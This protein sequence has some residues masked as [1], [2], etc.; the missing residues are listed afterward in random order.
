ML[1]AE[2]RIE[3]A[4]VR[5]MNHPATMAY[6][7]LI[8]VGDTRVSDEVPTAYTNGRDKTYGRAFVNSLSDKELVGLILH[9]AGHIMYQHAYLWKHLWKKNSD[10]ANQAAD[11]VVNIELH[12]MSIA[13]P[14]LLALPA[15]GLLDNSYRGMNTQQVFDLLMQN[16]GNTGGGGFDSHD[17]ED[18]SADECEAL[19][20]EVESAIREGSYLSG[21]KGGNAP[22][23][24]AELT[25]PKVNWHEQLRAFAIDSAKGSDD[26]SWRKLNRRWLSAGVLVP[27]SES[28]SVPRI[29]IVFDVSGSIAG[30]SLVSAFM[31]E[32]VSICN[33]L[34]PNVVDM[35]CCDAAI[36][37]HDVYD[38]TSY[39][40]LEQLR[41]FKGGGGTDMRVALDYIE[42][43]GLNPAVVV[44]LTDGY[45][46][47]PTELS[48]P[49]LWAITSRNRA[50]PVGTTIHI[51]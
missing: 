8:M 41:S 5:I 42:K 33:L 3:K 36:Q 2:Q 23:S 14:E 37:S 51:D 21:K 17:F 12:D 38:E 4:H 11:Y 15:N 43:Q 22:V 44:V 26:A 7:S 35:I 9:E 1:T 46:P 31:S 18:L 45:T 6:T 16:G 47:Y 49:T 28:V 19:S 34:K 10:V 39:A 30:S 40:Q 48:R 13:Y 24:F 20:K 32:V 27:A 50:A 29:S 25:A